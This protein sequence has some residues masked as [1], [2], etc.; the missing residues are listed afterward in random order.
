MLAGKRSGTGSNYS[1][2]PQARADP[3]AGM[4]PIVSLNGVSKRY[5]GVPAVMALDLDVVEGEFLT[6]L[7]PS[8][9]GKT[10]TLRL[11]SGFEMPDEGE[12]FIAGDRVNDIPPYRRNVNTV[13]QSYALFPHLNVFDNVAYSLSIRGIDKSTIRQRVHAMLKRVGLPEKSASMPHQLSGG[14]MQR[15]ALARALVNEPRVL[16]L[17]EPLSALDAKLRRSM[18][19]ELKHI[20]R[21]LGLSFIYVTHDQE[22]AL[23]LSDRIAVMHDG[24]IAQLGSPDSVFERPD[25]LFVA[26]FLGTSNV[27]Q[28]RLTG[29]EGGEARL[30]DEQGL[31]WLADASQAAAS[32]ADGAV[33]VV[34]RPQ[35]LYLIDVTAPARRENR[36]EATLDEVIYAGSSVRLLLR[37]A[38]DRLLVVENAPDRM[39]FDYRTL[40]SGDRLQ[41]GCAA[42]AL[43]LFA[44]QTGS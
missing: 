21:H 23:V 27:L 40:R 20:Q 6:L 39:P 8:G 5:G 19:L 18:Q 2:R 30:T 33:S 43:I 42:D 37:L 10:T 15:V 11:I 35:R 36:V 25:T 14:Q 3:I 13:F 26:D 22:E 4:Q 38:G 17:D 31:T 44:T 24:R 12:I 41:V 34:I 9:C 28:A 32:R 1:T 7:G 16:L 29:V